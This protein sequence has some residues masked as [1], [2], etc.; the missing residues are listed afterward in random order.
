MALL[1]WRETSSC[2]YSLF[3]V[4]IWLDWSRNGGLTTYLSN[5]SISIILQ[6]RF[7]WWRVLILIIAVVCHKRHLS[8]DCSK[9]SIFVIV[10]VGRMALFTIFDRLMI[11]G[12]YSWWW[13]SKKELW[14]CMHV[15]S[16][17]AN[18]QRVTLLLRVQHNSLVLH[19]IDESNTAEFNTSASSSSARL[20]INISTHTSIWIRLTHHDNFIYGERRPALRSSNS[21][22][23]SS[24]WNKTKS[25]QP[26]CSIDS[27]T[28]KK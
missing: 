23:H 13:L 2:A 15:W 20:R 6:W 5:W 7:N 3:R 9:E 1:D 12:L 18:K 11:Y 16:F 24:R 21:C 17:E 25:I 28:P 22:S 27:K 4:R 19:L 10:I 26:V 8:N 14:W